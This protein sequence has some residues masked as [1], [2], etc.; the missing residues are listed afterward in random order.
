MRYVSKH[1]GAVG[2]VSGAGDLVGVKVVALK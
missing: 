1:T 2:Y